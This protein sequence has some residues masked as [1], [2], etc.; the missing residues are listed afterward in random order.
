MLFEISNV[1]ASTTHIVALWSPEIHSM[2]GDNA[3]IGMFVVRF[4]TCVLSL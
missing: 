4:S 3:I 2:G 1:A